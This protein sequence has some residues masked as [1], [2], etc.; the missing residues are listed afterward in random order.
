[1]L[2][3]TW[4]WSLALAAVSFYP[5]V[6]AAQSMP[7]SPANF[8]NLQPCRVVDTR[9]GW[10]EL[11]SPSLVPGTRDFPILQSRCNIPS[12]ASAY[13]FNVTV[14]PKGTLSWLTLFPTGQ[15]KPFVSTLNSY[16]G[17]VVAN[18]AIIPAGVD[19]KVSVYVTDPTELIIDID[20]YFVNAGT[21][22]GSAGQYRGTWSATAQYQVGDITFYS[23]SSYLAT[24]A[25][26]NHQPDSDPTFW[27]TLARRG[28][29][30]LPGP[31]GIAGIQ[32]PQG[33][34]GL[35]GPIGLTG[36][37][38]AIGATGLTGPQGPIGLTGLTGATGAAG[39]NFLGQWSSATSYSVRD[40]VTFAGSTYMAILAGTNLQPDIS[41]TAWTILAQ[42]GAAPI[43]FSTSSTLNFVTNSV[44]FLPGIGYVASLLSNEADGQIIA[45]QNCTLNSLTVSTDQPAALTVA[46]RKNGTS[47]AQCSTAGTA[48]CSASSLGLSIAASDLIGYRVS[49]TTSVNTRLRVSASCQ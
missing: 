9:E 28:D 16:T 38:G 18:S 35:V 32:G 22:V 20:G 40:A 3:K 49:G 27:S 45:G 36:L 47:I 1:M 25:S 34:A 13:S 44:S 6:A 46:V 23:G 14:V 21:S 48:S 39:M 24:Q 15:D 33:P 43:A 29:Q 37:T 17:I 30:G 12:N 2:F 19:G 4:Y 11:G 26:T 42:K 10:G 31:Q 41:P 7:A 8:V 5:T